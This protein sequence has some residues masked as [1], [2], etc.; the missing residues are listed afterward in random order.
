MDE[1]NGLLTNKNNQLVFLN[2]S[3]ICGVQ[4]VSLSYVKPLRPF[5]YVGVKSAVPYVYQGEKITSITID[6]LL[7]DKDFFWSYTGNVPINGCILKSTQFTNT[8]V[9]FISGYL[10]SYVL[11]C[12]LGQ[13]PQISVQIESRYDAGSLSGIESNDLKSN[14]YCI[15]KTPFDTNYISIGAAKL[16]NNSQIVNSI[17]GYLGTSQLLSGDYFVFTGN[18][19][20]YSGIVTGVSSNSFNLSYTPPSTDI[21]GI[22]YKYINPKRIGPGSIDLN[23]SDF[24]TN[25]VNSI[26]LELNMRRIPIYTISSCVPKETLLETPS[27]IKVDVELEVNDYQ[28]QKIT[29]YP[30]Q[31]KIIDLSFNLLDYDDGSIIQSYNIGNMEL[32]GETYRTTVDGNTVCNLSFINYL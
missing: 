27:P 21:T 28:L 3:K 12:Q 5:S 17:S 14:L 32:V 26:K 2:S 19:S 18:G 13:I 16:N 10:T 30:S 1:L 29:S 6:K 7:I 31:R 15:S 25:R 4:S 22:G 11:N 9:S 24:N 23:I 8:N 20:L